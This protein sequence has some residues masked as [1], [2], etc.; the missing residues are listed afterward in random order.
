M[1]PPPRDRD[2]DRDKDRDTDRDTDREAANAELQAENAELHAK[3]AWLTIC[4]QQLQAV[5]AALSADNQTRAAELAR[6]N[7]RFDLMVTMLRRHLEAQAP[8]TRCMST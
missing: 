6:T 2:K 5:N 7:S 3:G 1:A 4:L 8:S